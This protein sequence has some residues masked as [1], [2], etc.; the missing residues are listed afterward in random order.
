M[1]QIPLSLPAKVVVG[2]HKS[3][4]VP[5]D[6][7]RHTRT[8]RH[9]RF[10]P[11]N[12]KSKRDVYCCNA[13]SAAVWP[14]GS[15]RTVTVSSE[16]AGFCCSVSHYFFLFFLFPFASWNSLTVSFR[17]HVNILH[18]IISYIVLYTLVYLVEA[19]HKSVKS[20][21][22]MRNSAGLRLQVTYK[23]HLRTRSK[24]TFT[25]RFR[26]HRSPGM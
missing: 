25:G 15:T 22:S 14:L 26:I 24:F 17:A 1:R 11:R 5:A 20:S 12:A 7:S 23:S 18:H 6:Q 10:L 16:H 19:V 2:R 3:C 21:C 4:D 9:S 13:V 8:H